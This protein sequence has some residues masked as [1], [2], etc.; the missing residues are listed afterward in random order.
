MDCVQDQAWP[1]M[2]SWG[3]RVLELL[4]S[5]AIVLSLVIA[6]IYAT[7]FHLWRGRSLRDLRAYAVAAVVGFLI[8]QLVGMRT[9]LGW[10]DVGSVNTIEASAFSW[11]ALFI[12]NRLKV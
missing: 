12:A 6:L 1:A 2:V 10:L 7:L 3:E 9:D 11:L 4:R 5:P 8:G